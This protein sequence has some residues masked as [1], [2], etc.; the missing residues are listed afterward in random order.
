MNSKKF[1]VI[2]AHAFIGWVFCAA[3]MGVGMSVMSL[4]NTLITHVIGA[5][6]FFI[7]VA[8]V[9][10][11]KFN[12]T[13]PMQTAFVFVGFVIFIDFFLVAL[14]INKSLDMFTSPLGTWIPFALIFASTYVTG[15]IV[16][17]KRGTSSYVN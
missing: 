4:E 6:I 16:N 8:L 9:Y 17:K 14:V 7:V 2:I 15:S 11:S 5:P 10:F 3:T 12:Y 1:L 13:S